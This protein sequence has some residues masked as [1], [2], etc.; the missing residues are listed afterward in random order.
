MLCYWWA[1]A[2]PSKSR[3]TNL[4]GCGDGVI[5]RKTFLTRYDRRVEWCKY[6]VICF[7]CRPAWL[8]DRP[9]LWYTP[10]PGERHRGVG[11]SCRL[12][13]RRDL[14]LCPVIEF[15]HLCKSVYAGRRDV[16]VVSFDSY[17]QWRQSPT[18]T[19]HPMFKRHNY[20]WTWIAA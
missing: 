13:E 4:E 12:V 6:H 17:C 5:W 19:G 7:Y 15:R 2:W 16:M 8:W 20:Q 11:P 9:P 1:M 18:P 10:L 14:P 3:L